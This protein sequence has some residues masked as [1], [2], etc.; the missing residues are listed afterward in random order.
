M[1]ETNKERERIIANGL[2][3]LP[4]LGS[5]R[6]RK[7]YEN[8]GCIESI[9]QYSKND[10]MELL[11]GSKPESLFQILEEYQHNPDSV[12]KRME[13]FCKEQEEKGIRF[14]FIG[15]EEYPNKL[16]RIS[17][18]PFGIYYKGHLPKQE[19]PMVSIIGAREC[20]E[21]GRKCA[22][23]FGETLAEYGVAIVSGMARGID[24]IS[25][26]AA[27]DTGGESFGILGCGVD[28]C[29]PEENRELYD[30]LILKGG[31]IS[32][33]PPGMP[34]K[35]N[36]FPARNRIISG[37]CDILLVV[38]ARKKS[39]TYITVC[40]ALEQGREIFAVPGRIT[41]GLSDGCNRL[42]SDG[43]GMAADPMMVLDALCGIN[44][45]S[46]RG[47]VK[48]EEKDSA[49]LI[50]V[51]DHCIRDN[52]LKGLNSGIGVG[53]ALLR[54]LEGTPISMEEILLRLEK[55]GIEISYADLMCELTD[56]CI[57]GRAE[58]IGNYYRKV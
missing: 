16:K 58:G 25:Q 57:D 23:M 37:M 28:I 35:S 48:A 53:S 24:G 12:F 18:P 41:D 36:H 17:D 55:L 4:K 29:Y 34:A 26:Q 54:I 52:V 22:K 1:S 2:Y 47:Y 32:E 8:I 30:Q 14:T 13:K 33:Y 50:D 11:S 6:L 43:A 27:L 3:V 44:G 45:A 39:G 46:S 42:I 31:I 56:L 19:T 51:G 5:K 7:L 10:L 21:Y 38:E 9:L 40:Q 49:I 20:S 15:E